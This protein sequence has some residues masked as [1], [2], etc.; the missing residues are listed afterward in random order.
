MNRIEVLARK[1]EEHISLPWRSH[2]A[3]GEKTIFVVYPKEDERRLRGK[4]ELFGQAC[5]KAGYGWDEIWLDSAF[6]EWM[7]SQEYKE[8][9][10]SFPEDIR[11]KLEMDFT[12]FAADR[13]RAQLAKLGESDALGVF[14]VGT[15]FGLTYL[16]SVLKR[17]EGAVPG[18]LVVFFPGTYEKNVYRLLD[19]RDGW[20]Y[21]AYSITLNEVTYS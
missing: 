16:S 3:T 20:G 11:Q 9:Y 10:F 14:G 15:L 18:R 7:A 2:L 12:R 5:R 13:L 17:L 6:P 4:R 21:M 19:A 1:F 8:E